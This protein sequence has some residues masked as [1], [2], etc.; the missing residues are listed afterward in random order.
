M[1]TYL[2]CVAE[3]GAKLL[4]EKVSEIRVNELAAIVSEVSE[5]EFGE[6]NLKKNLSRLAWVESVVRHHEAVMEELRAQTTIVPFRFPTIFHSQNS[7]QEFLQAQQNALKNLLENLKGKEE[8]GVKVYIG[9]EQLQAFL[10]ESKEIQEIDE[11]LKTAS[12]GKAYLLKKRRESLLAGNITT[13]L[14]AALDALFE[15]LRQAS[16]QSKLNPVLPKAVTEREDEMIL[17]GAFLIDSKKREPFLEELESARKAFPFF[18]IEPS[19]A[20]AA[21]NFCNLQQPLKQAT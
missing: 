12:A 1:L 17:N 18:T 8:W 14:Q 9:S 6:E 11:A 15:R 10:S 13:S 7:L 21:Y 2:Y 16:V 19:G 4:P 5:A 20:W 3:L